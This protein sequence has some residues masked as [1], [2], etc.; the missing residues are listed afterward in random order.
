MATFLARRAAESEPVD[1]AAFEEQYRSEYYIKTS[2]LSR[3]THKDFG[4]ITKGGAFKTSYM[5]YYFLGKSIATNPE[6]AAA[7]LPE[8]CAHSYTEANYLTLLFAIHHA[9]DDKIIEDIRNRTVVELEDVA[10]ATLSE[11]ET[12]RFANIVSGAPGKRAVG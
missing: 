3:L 11:A 9:T 4:I 1:F 7:Y 6:H 5:Y 8:L 12:S 10:V 2:L